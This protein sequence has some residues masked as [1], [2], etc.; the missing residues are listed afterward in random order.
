[1]A[2]SRPVHL[3][4]SSSI[5]QNPNEW[6]ANVPQKKRRRAGEPGG[7]EMSLNLKEMIDIILTAAGPSRQKINNVC[8]HYGLVAN[9]IKGKVVGWYG[10]V[11][12]IHTA[13]IV[14]VHLMIHWLDQRLERLEQQ[15]AQPN[16]SF[17]GDEGE[18]PEGVQNQ[19]S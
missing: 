8:Q 1:M 5:A 4:G 19:G 11:E 17:S 7:N 10:H 16:P 14:A 9:Y 18:T 13:D 6:Q 2:V 3:L 15:L 12:E